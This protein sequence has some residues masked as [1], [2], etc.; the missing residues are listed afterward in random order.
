MI[1]IITHLIKE[2]SSRG[3]I[4]TKSSTAMAT[5]YKCEEMLLEG[6]T[7]IIQAEERCRTNEDNND[8]FP[9]F[10]KE[11]LAHNSLLEIQTYRKS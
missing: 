10:E 7:N 2:I 1:L 3:H 8:N 6:M 4:R 11:E 9:E 5:A